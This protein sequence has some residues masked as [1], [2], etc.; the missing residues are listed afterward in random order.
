MRSVQ[1]LTTLIIIY[2]IF[3]AIGTI[4]TGESRFNLQT[5]SVEDGVAYLAGV[6]LSLYLQGGAE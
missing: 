4:V 6:A 3:S 2:F 5:W 1:I